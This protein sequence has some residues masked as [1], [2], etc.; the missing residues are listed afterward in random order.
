MDAYI[1]STANAA[2]HDFVRSLGP[3]R[4]PDTARSH[5]KTGA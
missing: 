1:T 5:S 3:M 2:K 4:L